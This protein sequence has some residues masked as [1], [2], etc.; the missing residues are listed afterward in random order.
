MVVVQ[1]REERVR[2][3]DR[4]MAALEQPVMRAG[5]VVQDDESWPTSIR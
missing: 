4:A 1:M 5:A 2:D 3:V